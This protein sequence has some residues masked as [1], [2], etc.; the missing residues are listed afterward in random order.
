MEIG[1]VVVRW[2]L[3]ESSGVCVVV[4]CSCGRQCSSCVCVMF[5]AELQYV[6][7]SLC[8]QGCIT[9]GIFL[10]SHPIGWS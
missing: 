9:E 1:E 10:Y 7:G 6:G 3:M 5:S 2:V 8:H 4:G